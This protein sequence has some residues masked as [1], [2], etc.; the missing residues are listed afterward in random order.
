M[1]LWM[2]GMEAYNRC[3]ARHRRRRTDP[4]FPGPGKLLDGKRQKPG[5][6][7]GFRLEPVLLRR[8]ADKAAR[9]GAKISRGGDPL[10]PFNRADCG[11]GGFAGDGFADLGRSGLRCFGFWCFGNCCRRSL[12]GAG[13]GFSRLGARHDLSSSRVKAPGA[14][15]RLWADAKSGPSSKSPPKTSGCSA[16]A[17]FLSLVLGPALQRSPVMHASGRGFLPGAS[18]LCAVPG[19]RS[20]RRGQNGRGSSSIGQIADSRI[21]AAARLVRRSYPGP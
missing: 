10:S 6:Q 5:H 20:T 1:L 17:I 15:R 9:L 12:A 4:G 21:F 11:P 8:S 7:F 16:R 18:G 19:E 14:A 2:N 13:A 3:A